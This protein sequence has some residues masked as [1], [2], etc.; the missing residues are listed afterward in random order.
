M[1]DDN[2]DTIDIIYQGQRQMVQKKYNAASPHY[3]CVIVLIQIDDFK[4]GMN[5]KPSIYVYNLQ[6]RLFDLLSAMTSNHKLTEQQYIAARVQYLAA[7]REFRRDINYWD[8]NSEEI[9]DASREFNVDEVPF[10]IDK[11]NK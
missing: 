9:W 1:N 4:K 10:V 7:E 11:K 6:Q 3:H 5:L 8:D 2:K